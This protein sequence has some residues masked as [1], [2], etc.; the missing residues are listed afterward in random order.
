MIDIAPGLPTREPVER[1]LRQLV[2]VLGEAEAADVIAQVTAETGVQRLQSAQQ[3]LTVAQ[4]LVRRGGFVEVVGRMLKAQAL[5]AGARL[6]E[7]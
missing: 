5:V 1:A 7:R 3:V 4:A 2:R 6:D